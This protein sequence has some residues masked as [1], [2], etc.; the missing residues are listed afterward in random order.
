MKLITLNEKEFKKIADKD[1]KISFYQTIEWAKL[2]IK[3]NW[4][5]HFL[6]LEDNGKII[7]TS[8][9]LS[10][11]LPFIKKNMF[12]SPRGFLIDYDNKKIL[13]EWTEQLKNYV[14][15]ENGIFIKIDPYMEYQQRDINGNIVENGFNNKK[16]HENLLK[17]KYKHFGFNKVSGTIQPRWIY[18]LDTKN[19]TLEEINKDIEPK[20]RQILR[21]NERSGIIVREI[22]K[23]ELTI[24]KE[25]MQKTSN[26]REFI[27]RPYS[28]YKTMWDNLYDNKIL[29]IM[30]AEIDFNLY[31]K[32]TKEELE[33]HKNNIKDRTYKYENKILNM[34]EKKYLSSNKQD[35]IEIK[36]LKN[37]LTKIKEYKKTYGNK[38]I[39]GG[40]LFLVY[41]NEIISL[42]GGTL[43]NL[44]IFKSAYS[45]HYAGIKYAVE[46]KL[47]RYNFY[48]ITGDFK[49]SN[50][51]YGLYLFKKSFGGHVVELMG[52]YDYIISPF[53]YN[54]YNIL[55]KT[56]RFT[57]NTIKK[58]TKH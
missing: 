22:K 48:G 7:T 43:D 2:K 38:K 6:A 25:I 14:K 36:R 32:N 19:K 55:F 10:K 16:A 49:E 39:L 9:L 1:E 24:F 34:N 26:R 13:K 56:Y 47:N 31:E 20:T 54:T 4:K 40:I 28:Y 44:L 53:W 42:L 27:D 5:A 11:P 30:F 15:K 18:I 52:E 29:K 57:K 33:K 51:L 41:K 35:E 37:D 46:N 3:N 21:K 45:I 8:L 50:P 58:V 12:Y 17:L 23:D